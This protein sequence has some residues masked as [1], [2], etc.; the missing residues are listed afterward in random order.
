M[1][2]CPDINS[3]EYEEIIAE[4]I[5]SLTMIKYNT[6]DIYEVDAWIKRNKL[7]GAY[8]IELFNKVS[9]SNPADATAFILWYGGLK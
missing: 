9:F 7:E 1:K 5:D 8:I 2:K 6:Q 3:P 4:Y